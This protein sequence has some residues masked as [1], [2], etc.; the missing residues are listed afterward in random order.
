ME[1]RATGVSSNL[2]RVIA[3][4]FVFLLHG[5]S[6]I[7]KI[8]D[9]SSPFNWLTCFPAWAGVWIFLILSGY[10]IGYGFSTKRYPLINNGEL[11]I[12]YFLRFYVGRFVKIAPLYY[13]YCFFFEILSGK[14][15][16]W[17]NPKYL[18]QMLTFTF[19]GNGGISGLGHL[20]YVSLAMQL[21]LAMPFLYILIGFLKKK[22]VPLVT[23]YGIAVVAG[24]FIRTAIV[25]HGYDWY[26]RCYTNFL[27]NLDLVLAGMLIAEM[28][29]SFSV[30]LKKPTLLKGLAAMLFIGL[31]LYNCFIYKGATDAQLKIYR[32]LLPSVYAATC[33]LLLLLSGNGKTLGQKSFTKRAVDWLSGHTYSF[34]IFHI[35]VFRYLNETMIQKPWF[36]QAGVG[37]QYVTFFFVSFLFTLILAIPFDWIGKK[38]VEMYKPIERKVFR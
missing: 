27:P 15:Y 13:L 5:R 38:F 3:T 19:N 8:N 21:Y 26:S 1:K 31:T 16:F 22:K 32:C 14:V 28:R 23:V 17:K 10:A 2:L 33:G 9:L 18:V 20:W 29:T 24:L 11:K 6:Y 7:P 37:K 35:A 4:M 12:R 25:S 34:Y 30:Q 36:A